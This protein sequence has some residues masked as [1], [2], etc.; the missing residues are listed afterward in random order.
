[1][2]ARA[3]LVAVAAL[4]C[5]GMCTGN[6]PL[7]FIRA[8]E[9]RF[10]DK[11]CNE[12]NFVGTN[13][14][15]RLPMPAAR[16]LTMTCSPPGG[17]GGCQT[18]A[19]PSALR[20]CRRRSCDS[21]RYS[22]KGPRMLT[23]TAIEPCRHTSCIG[24]LQLCTVTCRKRMP[25]SQTFRAGAALQMLTTAAWPWVQMAHAFHGCREVPFHGRQRLAD[26]DVVATETGEA[27]G[28]VHEPRALGHP[29]DAGMRVTCCGACIN[30]NICHYWPHINGI[31][32]AI[33]RRISR[34]GPRELTCG[35]SAALELI[36][37]PYHT[38]MCLEHIC[39]PAYLQRPAEYL[40]QTERA[41]TESCQSAF[42]HT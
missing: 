11:D 1:M 18:S 12:F 34:Q 4:G 2:G 14:C 32:S 38:Q 28:R 26:I 20:H 37:S 23:L 9:S 8:Q 22:L 24:P 39:L 42:L 41:C 21:Q 35:V 15:V 30:V 36:Y 17:G 31:L 13:A 40:E 33:W 10:V 6:A 27:G 19:H 5:L 25:V 16:Y 3:V 29:S 7:G